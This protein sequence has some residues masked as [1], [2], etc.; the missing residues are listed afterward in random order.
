MPIRM[1]RPKALADAYSL[2]RLQEITVAALQNKPKPTTKYLVTSYTPATLF[3]SKHST[4]QAPIT[5]QTTLNTHNWSS[6]NV[7]SKPTSVGILPAPQIMPR[8]QTHQSQRNT[9]TIS[10]KD[11]DARRARGLCFWCDEKFIPGHRCKKKQLYAMQLQVETGDAFVVLEELDA[12]ENVEQDNI[13]LSLNALLGGGDYQTMTL[14][15]TYRGRPLFV[16]IDYGSTL[17]FL[18]TKV[19]K[20]VKCPLQPVSNIKVIVANGQDLVC[21]MVCLDF[22]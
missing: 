8:P 9:K 22:T 13:Q 6:T 10:N 17:N 7:P 16:L 2:A 20:R 3:Q 11:L 5:Q 4:V 21:T 1:F 15:S 14:T 12:L 18:S 19:A